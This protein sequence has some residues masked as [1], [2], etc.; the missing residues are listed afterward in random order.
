MYNF[1]QDV[2][3]SD[4]FFEFHILEVARPT[5]ISY[6]MLVENKIV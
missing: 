2:A 6:G 1:I 3:S 5:T 4:I